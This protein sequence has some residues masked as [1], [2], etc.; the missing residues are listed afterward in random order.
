MGG[1]GILVPS[2]VWGPADLDSPSQGAAGGPQGV[3]AA[4]TFPDL[5][6]AKQV[7]ATRYPSPH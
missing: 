7:G 3:A 6:W 1:E 4:M 5:P 2:K